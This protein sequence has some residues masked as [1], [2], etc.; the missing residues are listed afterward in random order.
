MQ[1]WHP[2]H[3]HTSSERLMDLPHQPIAIALRGLLRAKGGRITK[4]RPRR[5]VPFSLVKPRSTNGA[6]AAWP[7]L[8]KYS[9]P[10]QIVFIAETS[11]CAPRFGA[12]EN[13]ARVTAIPG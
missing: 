13:V 12:F 6:P 9:R 3:C 1:V 7:H 4:H 11:R 8:A 5:P 10:M 2:A